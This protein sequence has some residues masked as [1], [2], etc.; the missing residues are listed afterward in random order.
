[1]IMSYL[2]TEY[3]LNFF[4]FLLLIFFVEVGEGKNCHGSVSFIV[5]HFQMSNVVNQLM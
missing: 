4:F 5:K 1:M 2:S 3:G